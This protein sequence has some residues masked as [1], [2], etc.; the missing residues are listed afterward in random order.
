M[1]E[2]ELA[3]V[4]ARKDQPRDAAW[5]R[6]GLAKFAHKCRGKRLLFSKMG[7]EEKEEGYKQ[8]GETR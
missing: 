8:T 2:G 7:G 3:V 5:V 6:I 1:W 4:R